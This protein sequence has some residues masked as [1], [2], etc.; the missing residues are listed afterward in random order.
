MIRRRLN[1]I[2]IGQT[3]TIDRLDAVV[4]DSNNAGQSLGVEN[5]QPNHVPFD[6]L[7]DGDRA[8]WRRHQSMIGQTRMRS[9]VLVCSRGTDNL[10][11]LR[12]DTVMPLRWAVDTV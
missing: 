10:I 4:L 12:I 8:S 2:A 9:W 6:D 1:E 3:N 5:R 11:R 7:T